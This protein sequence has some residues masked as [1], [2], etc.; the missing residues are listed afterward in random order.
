M[1][2]LQFLPVPNLPLIAPGADL[3]AVIVGAMTQNEQVFLAGDIV[4]VA[5]K[6]VSKAENRFVKLSEVTPSERAIELAALTDKDPRL[7]EVILWDTAEVI[8]AKPGVLIVEHKA[9]FI[10]AN[11]GVDRSNIAPAEEEMV[12][13][14]PADAD[15]SAARLRDRLA[16][17]TGRRPPVLIIDSH[18]RPWRLGVVGV[19]IGLAGIKPV[20]DLRGQPDLFGV[21][22]KHTTVGAADELAAAAS[23]VMGQTAA[24]CP[25]VI[26]RGLVY[27]ADETTRLR[28]VIRDKE[29]DLFR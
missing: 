21:P 18:G 25:V 19:V 17:L 27:E 2:V 24:Q 16:R 4:L 15:A 9:G 5:Q 7:V 14:L 20:W 11:A 28:D 8:R 26:A 23:L 29:R 22:L 12:L 1:N 6:I 10:S 3:G 13:R